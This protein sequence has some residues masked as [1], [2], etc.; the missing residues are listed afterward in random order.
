MPSFN[1]P[2]VTNPI[3][4]D[5]SEIRELLQILAKHDY[6]GVDDTPTG[7]K[8][9]T[10]VTGGMQL[11][12]FSNNSW[13]SIGK[14]M[15]DVDKLDGYHASITAVKKTIPVYNDN[16]QLPGDI[17]GNAATSTK[18]KTARTIDV[19]GI[20][21]ATEKKFDGSGNITIPINSINVANDDDNALVGVV[22]KAHGGT[23]RTDG[24]ATDVIL[25][26]GGKA[27]EYGQIG[28]S[29]DITGIS[30]DT[31]VEPGDYISY[32]MSIENSWPF[33][34]STLIG[35]V[36]VSRS[37]RY[38]S[39]LLFCGGETLWQRFSTNTGASWTKLEPSGGNRGSSITIYISKS[40][41][42]K[43]TGMDNTH[44]VLTINRALKIAD[45]WKPTQLNTMVKLCLGEGDWGDVTFSSLPYT[46]SIYPYDGVAA[47]S[48]SESLPKFGTLS[49]SGTVYAN[50]RGVVADTL[51]ANAG[52]FV[53]ISN[54]VTRFGQLRSRNSATINIFKSTLEVMNTSSSLDV[55][56]T[57]H[58]GRIVVGS[59]STCKVIENISVATAFLYMTICSEI[60]NF[61]AI[62]FSVANGVQVSGKKYA[63]NSGSS[64]HYATKSFLDK[65]PGTIAGVL[66]NGVVVNG[67]PYGGGA[68]DK[69]LMADLSWK[70]V[71]L[72]TGGTLTGPLLINNRT[73]SFTLKNPEVTKGQAPSNN[74][75]WSIAFVDNSPELTIDSRIGLIESRVTTNGETKTSISA[76]RYKE[77]STNSAHVS[78]VNKPDGTTYGEAPTPPSD[79]KS[80]EIATASWVNTKLSNYLPTTEGTV[81]GRINFNLY[82]TADYTGCIVAK[83]DQYG[84]MLNID[85]YEE[86]DSGAYISLRKGSDT[87]NPGGFEINVRN[88]EASVT[89][90]LAARTDGN[91]S[92]DGKQI[93]RSVNGVTADANGNVVLGGFAS[94]NF[95]LNPGAMIDVGTLS[96]YTVPCSGLFTCAVQL[97]N[98]VLGA[99]RVNGVDVA[100]LRGPD[101]GYGPLLQSVSLVVGAR[102]TIT[103]SGIN[104]VY[105]RFI[106]FLAV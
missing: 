27:S 68:A 94:G 19:G 105:S 15:H 1:N 24:A 74:K 87:I 104:V 21:S 92:W 46:L 63:I 34:N 30:L 18:L 51:D 78:V 40:G 29:K 64:V 33:S 45:G 96:S 20:A 3:N 84:K 83:N 9:I 47:T 38:I 49:F 88:A 8:R 66:S 62:T 60:L 65:L 13:S 32:G 58:G 100:Y 69:A 48:Y 75:Y 26:N 77:N 76:Y 14:L 67:L 98:S 11:Q 61:E 99:I 35:R 25:A 90:V 73:N 91:L 55:I 6:T 31:L 44:P 79:A 17:T 39:Q 89:K 7:A 23:G 95:C 43:N 52:A 36:R 10:T 4:S 106:P 97:G 57:Y 53:D 22:S 85:T 16:A 54:S 72:Q 37:G 12:N 93:V 80:T 86:G 5:V 102:N 50:T 82:G 101:Y 2:K 70:P 28:Y 56:R 42:D 71:L 81:N 103:H 59:A 41:N